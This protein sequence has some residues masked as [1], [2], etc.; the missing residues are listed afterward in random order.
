[1]ETCSQ[2][3]AVSGVEA[4]KDLALAAFRASVAEFRMLPEEP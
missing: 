1:V 4:L 3:D 2:R